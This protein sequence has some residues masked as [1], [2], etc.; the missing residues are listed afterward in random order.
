MKTRANN[1]IL[2]LGVGIEHAGIGPIAGL[3]GLMRDIGIPST[4]KVRC[5]WH[6]L[7]FRRDTASVL[8]ADIYWRKP[9]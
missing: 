2:T 5:G 9:T 8:A 3:R 1:D 4:Y 6:E 7:G